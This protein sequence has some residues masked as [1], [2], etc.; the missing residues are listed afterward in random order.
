MA[1]RVT[2]RDRAL[3]PVTRMILDQ[4]EA[5][6]QT[7]TYSRFAERAQRLSGVRVVPHYHTARMLDFY[8]ANLPEGSEDLAHLVVHAHTGTLGSGYERRGEG[9]AGLVGAL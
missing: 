5:A 6:E 8:V 1:R 4:V 2:K 7:I 9:F 3:L